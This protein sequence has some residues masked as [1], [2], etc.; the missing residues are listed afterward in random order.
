ML[1]EQSVNEGIFSQYT[2]SSALRS[3][4]LF[5]SQVIN[6]IM[7]SMFSVQALH[8]V[9]ASANFLKISFL[10]LLLLL[11]PNTELRH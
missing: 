5:Y 6:F 11:K 3:K 7:I 8:F 2:S 10:L 9:I 1:I 4:P